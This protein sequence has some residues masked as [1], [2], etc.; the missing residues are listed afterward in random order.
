MM[1]NSPYILQRFVSAKETEEFTSYSK[2]KTIHEHG[3]MSGEEART[4]YEVVLSSS[5]SDA[6]S[7]LASKNNKTE[8]NN[9]RQKGNGSL[10]KST[11][12]KPTEKDLKSKKNSGHSRSIPTKFRS[13]SDHRLVNDFL[14]NA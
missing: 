1:T 5:N 4:F 9:S 2:E 12:S 6:G 10:A 11:Y 14:K 3:S 7:V 13:T 8:K